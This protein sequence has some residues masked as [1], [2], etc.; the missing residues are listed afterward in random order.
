[1]TKTKSKKAKKKS[2]KVE[3]PAFPDTPWGHK[4]ADKAAAAKANAE[5]TETSTE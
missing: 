3:Q 4:Q 5:A 2:E 1:M